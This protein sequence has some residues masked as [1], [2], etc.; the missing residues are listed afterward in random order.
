MELLPL[1]GEIMNEEL[2]YGDIQSSYTEGVSEIIK[3][4]SSLYH[5]ARHRSKGLHIIL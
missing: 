2:R 3:K 4:T 5:G 1:V